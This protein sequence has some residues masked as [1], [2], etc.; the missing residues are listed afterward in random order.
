MIGEFFAAFLCRNVFQYMHFDDESLTVS[1]F[2][3]LNAKNCN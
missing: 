1:A 2:V 3:E